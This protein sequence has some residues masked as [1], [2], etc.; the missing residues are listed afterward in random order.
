MES[1]HGIK[2][3]SNARS[4]E[5]QIGSQALGAVKRGNLIK[6]Y[7]NLKRGCK[8]DG[9]GSFQY[10][11]VKD[12]RQQAHTEEVSSEY[13]ELLCCEGDQ[14]LEQVTQRGC[15]IFIHEGLQKLYGH[16]PE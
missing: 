6:A 11:S 12:K 10:H 5:V 3:Q 7:K 2:R 13:Q 1:F 15:E 8:E 16:N 9:P 4:S 14:V